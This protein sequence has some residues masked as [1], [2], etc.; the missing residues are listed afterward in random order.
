MSQAESWSPAE[1]K[2]PHQNRAKAL[3][4]LRTRLYELELEGSSRTRRPAPRPIGTGDRSEKI[5]TYNF[6]GSG[7]RPPHQADAQHRLESIL[8]G[9]LDEFANALDPRRSATT[10]GRL[11]RAR[12]VRASRRTGRG[13]RRPEGGRLESPGLDA[14]LLMADA[15]ASIAT[16]CDGP[17]PPSRPRRPG[18]GERLRRRCHASRP[19]TSS[20][21]RAFVI[22]LTVDAG[23]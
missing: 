4:V 7:H 5:R 10:R 11:A 14:Q 23:C 1:R 21:A 8:N 20:A 15:W 13:G 22:E 16:R 18:L 17:G 3:G 12:R 9:E 6:R 2:V 19:R